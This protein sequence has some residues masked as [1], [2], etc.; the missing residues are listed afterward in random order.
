M[1]N[2][3]IG[4]VS[5]VCSKMSNRLNKLEAEDTTVAIMKLEIGG[6]CTL[7]A[8]TAARPR[9]FEASVSILGEK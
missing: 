1:L 5:S 4:P 2:W 3:L 7:E 9:D 6:L 8:T